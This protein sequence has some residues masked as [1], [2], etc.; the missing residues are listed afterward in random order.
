MDHSRKG[1]EPGNGSEGWVVSVADLPA[2]A[3]AHE[4]EGGDYGGLGFSLIIVEV[5]VLGQAR[6]LTPHP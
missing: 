4:L 3:N 5:G 6:H 1:L 2:P